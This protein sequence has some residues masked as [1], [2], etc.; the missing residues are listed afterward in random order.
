MDDGAKAVFYASLPTGGKGE[1]VPGHTRWADLGPQAKARYQRM[2]EAAV[3][4]Y[5]NRFNVIQD[6]SKEV[7][8]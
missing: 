3:A 4:A 5:L 2:Y 8:R 7:N 1:L 6:E